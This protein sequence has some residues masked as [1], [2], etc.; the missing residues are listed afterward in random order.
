V[1]P[2]EVRRNAERMVEELEKSTCA[3]R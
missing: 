2:E 1:D 3:S